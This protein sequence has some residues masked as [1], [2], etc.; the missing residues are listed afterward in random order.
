MTIQMF[1]WNKK[2]LVSKA[3]FQKVLCLGFSLVFFLTSLGVPTAQALV[4]A[5]QSAADNA[6]L[7][8]ETGIPYGDRWIKH[9]KEDLLPF[10]ELETARPENGNFPTYRCNDGS[11]FDPNKPCPELVNP[12][13]GIVKLD[14]EYVRSKSRQVFAY[15]VAYNLTGEAKYLQWAK[16]G[17]DFL[18]KYALVDKPGVNPDAGNGTG[19]AYT[20]FAANDQSFAGKPEQ[21]KRI[22]QDMTYALSGLTFFYYLTRDPEI[23]KDIVNVKNYIFDYYYDKEWDLISWAKTD[24]IDYVNPDGT[25]EKVSSKQRELVAQL[26]QVY[27]YMI[28]IAPI[29]PDEF[30][31]V[32]LKKQWED[33]L[34]HLATIMSEQ[35]YT[36]DKNIFWGAITDSASKR[37]A[38]DHTDFGHSI[39]T[40]WLIYSIGKLTGHYEFVLFA[41]EAA[42]KIL[43]TAYLDD[44]TW[45]RRENP[46]GTIDPDKEWWILAELDQVAAT[47]SLRD[48][49]YAEYLPT[50]YAYWFKYMVDREHKE[51][52]HWVNAADNKPDIQFPKQH[53]WKNA[54]HTFEHA[55]VGYLTGQEIHDEPSKLYF[56]F[57]EG[58]P[59]PEITKIRPYIYA[60][61]VVPINPTI[62]EEE[63]I[64]GYRKKTVFFTDIR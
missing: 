28:L 64:P 57:K 49:S 50:T 61:K 62:L 31:G 60:A 48:P 23:L 41:Q 32:Q 5:K 22:S 1:S 15:G 46:D 14:R 19:G 53:S 54:F 63:V 56:A 12:V 6:D 16:N 42:P 27:A 3:F 55:I 40:L 8:I 39:K 44:G 7:V 24:Y 59:L 11:L 52:W 47:F 51:I 2:Q 34:V 38:T 20:Y 25:V 17:V 10:W 30:N 13:P 26:D 29:L 4:V 36:P 35:F 9:L 18:R 37:L 43:E 21:E 45:G 33:D 58:I